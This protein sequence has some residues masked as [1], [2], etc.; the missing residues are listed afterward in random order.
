MVRKSVLLCACVAAALSSPA[1]AADITIGV[2]N[3]AAAEAISYMLETLIERETGLDV[4]HVS[5]TNPVIFEAM[6]NGDMDVH[7]DVWLPNQANLTERFVEKE[8]T[9]ALSDNDY[10]GFAGFCVTRKTAEALKI[11]SIYDLADPDIAKQF[12]TDGDGKGEVWVGA[13]GWAGTAIDTVRLTTYGVGETFQLLEMDET[14]AIARMKEASASGKPFATLCF[15][16]HL[17]FLLADLV[18]LEEPAYDESKWT[19]VQPTDDPNWL[20]KSH[21]EVAYPPIRIQIAYARRLEEEAP[22]ALEI[23]RGVQL[24]TETVNQWNFQIVEEK[25]PVKDVIDT[26][27]AANKERVDGWLGF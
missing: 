9:V 12:D 10:G 18:Q 13:S 21:I 8:G 24:D 22:R 15:A 6:H 14:I 1:K 23:M 19:M 4:D 5:S 27:L 11:K 2:P 3:W 16:P 17:M 26:W 20:E 25:R 7:P